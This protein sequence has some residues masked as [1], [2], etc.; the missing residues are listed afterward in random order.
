MWKKTCFL[1]RGG[2]YAFDKLAKLHCL[3]PVPRITHGTS[4]LPTQSTYYERLPV[5]SC[6]TRGPIDNISFGPLSV[7]RDEVT[8]MAVAIAPRVR[9]ARTMPRSSWRVS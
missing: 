1:V 8:T 6:R 2:A 9:G 3:Q 7:E 4:T 5:A